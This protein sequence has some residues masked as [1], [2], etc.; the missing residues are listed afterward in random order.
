MSDRQVHLSKKGAAVLLMCFGKSAVKKGLVR[1]KAGIDEKLDALRGVKRA[2]LDALD[3][4]TGELQ[5]IEIKDTGPGYDDFDV[6]AGPMAL[7]KEEANHLK[8]SYNEILDKDG[9]PAGWS[10][11]VLEVEEAINAWTAEEA[12]TE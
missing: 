2:R 10:R 12:V 4:T 11:G 3:A 1:L 6:Q 7:S 9:F 5:Y 8:E